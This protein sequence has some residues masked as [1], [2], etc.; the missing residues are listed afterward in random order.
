[1]QLDALIAAGVVEDD[2]HTDVGSGATMS[3]PGL[4]AALKGLRPDD[5]LVIWKLDRLSR[6]LENTL[7]L[8]ADIG[9]KGAHLHSL[10]EQIDTTTAGGRLIFHMF[11][12]LADFERGVSNERTIAGLAAARARGRVGGRQPVYT[13]EQRAAAMQALK[14]GA[15]VREAAERIGVSRPVIYKWRK[16]G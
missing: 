15:S 7:K 11:A 8:A 1:M 5:V 6:K 14:E 9:A 4:R 13:E 16:M 10:T 2:I 12:M 3:R